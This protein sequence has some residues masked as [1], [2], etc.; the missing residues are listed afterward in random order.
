MAW[1][2]QCCPAS[3]SQD[4]AEAVLP[5][6][7]SVGSVVTFYSFKGGT[8]RSMAL[9]N[10]AC[11]LARQQA[12]A[13]ILMIDWDLEAPGLDRYFQGQI[14]GL[15]QTQPGLIDFFER[16][17]HLSGD[18]GDPGRPEDPALIDSIDPQAYMVRTGPG[19]LWLMTAG[20]F[21]GSYPRRVSTF[22]WEAFYTRRPGF[23]GVFAAWLSQRFSHVL[24]DSRTGITDTSGICTMLMPEKLVVV[25]TP[26]HQSLD[27]ALSQ[28]RRA[29]E[30]RLASGDMR[31]LAVFPLPSRIEQSEPA[32]K[33]DWRRGRAEAG[34]RGY[35][36]GFEA[37]FTDIY[38]LERCDLDHYFDEVQ[39]QY[40]APYAY[41]EAIATLIED[42]RDRLSLAS[43]YA[44]FAERLT[45]TSDAWTDPVRHSVPADE[46]ARSVKESERLAAALHSARR[47]SQGWLITAGSALAV[48]AGLAA[49]ALPA[50]W[51]YTTRAKLVEGLIMG[52]EAKQA[53][54]TFFA[55]QGKLPEAGD[56]LARLQ[57]TGVTSRY[58]KRVSVRAGGTVAIE[59]STEVSAA[60]G[61]TLLLRPAPAPGGGVLAWVCDGNGID[62]KYLTSDCRP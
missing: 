27:G 12:D 45:G 39:I 50:Y 62:V 13:E 15:T 16:A 20:R 24:I 29:T 21:D 6:R 46:L 59:Y 3:P 31:P 18:P 54:A 4:V 44:R 58:V 1:S 2:R 60:V 51:D 38:A 26:N 42:E 19:N 61:K 7:R 41:G 14:G 9:A 43:S 36:R 33:A 28:V 10:I 25:F 49:I 37:L 40:V 55:E 34:I 47:A 53:V 11:Q 48:L 32:R 35:Q 57:P 56:D 17:D 8:G 30:Y 52:S 22:N 5:I 23:F